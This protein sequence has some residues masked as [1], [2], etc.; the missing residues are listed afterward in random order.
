MARVGDGQKAAAEPLG[1][2]HQQPDAAQFPLPMEDASG[3]VVD[4]SDGRL[5]A[6]YLVALGSQ[7]YIAVM[8]VLEA[9]VT[10]MTPADVVVALAATGHQL[11]EK[12]VIARL[13]QLRT[14]GN[15]SARTD[16]SRI[17][18]YQDIVSKNWRYTATPRAARCTGFSR[19]CCPASL[20]CER[21]H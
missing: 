8:D 12:V 3:R 10:D 20:W 4:V 14:W 13:D 15:A 19:T 7:D 6:A 5:V 17:L 9:S 1:A 11:D 18:R 21:S 16:S 2:A